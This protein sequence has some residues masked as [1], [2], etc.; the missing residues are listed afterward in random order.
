MKNLIKLSF[1]FFALTV[2]SFAANYTLTAANVVPSSQ[3]KYL[4]VAK[5]GVAITAGQPVYMDT[6]G[7]WQL[8]DCNASAVAAD[9]QGLAAHTAAAGQPL[10]VVYEDAD[11]THGLT[12][13]AA[14]DV[15]IVSATAGALA[16]AADALSGYY[17]SVAMVATSA[18][19]AVL[20][21]V[22][23]GVAK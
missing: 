15:V 19:K 6:A 2:A 18:T 9:V 20:K 21:F 17:V 23:S 16:P 14:G 11:F 3:A 13:V 10:L 7:L 5:A 4:N 1:L 8:A 22:K 12:T